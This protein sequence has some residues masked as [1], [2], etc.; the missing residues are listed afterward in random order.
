MIKK[1]FLVSFILVLQFL[2]AEVSITSSKYNPYVNEII[3]IKI[4]IPGNDTQAP[5]K[6][7]VE[8]NIYKE[9]DHWITEMSYFDT[10][11]NKNS[12][13]LVYTYVIL[14]LEP[15]ISEVYY[16]YD[17][18][19]SNI[20]SLNIEQVNLNKEQPSLQSKLSDNVIYVRE[21][22][23]VTNT[24]FSTKYV[25]D[26]NY[27]RPFSKMNTS[28]LDTPSRS[29]IMINGSKGQ[30][31]IVSAYSLSSNK[32]GKF[33]ISE[34]EISLGGELV[35]I[36]SHNVEVIKLPEN[37]NNTTI[38]GKSLNIE[39]TNLAEEYKNGD[40]IKF[41]I[42]ISGNANLSG[43]TSLKDYFKVPEYVT[44]SILSRS[45]NVF[46]REMQHN[47]KFSY[48]GTLNS[49]VGLTINQVE[50]PFFNT[51]DKTTKFITF[52]KL[53]IKGNIS[54]ILLYTG[55]IVLLVIV[56][57]VII[58][59]TNFLKKKPRDKK[60]DPI[61]KFKF[62]NREKDIFAI[63]VNGKSTKEIAE[64]LYISPETVKKHIQNILKKTNTN[65][66]LEL[67]AL[68]NSIK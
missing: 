30:Y 20:I 3:E 12:S 37:I 19:T 36:P 17:K 15:G 54:G 60:S 34:S 8:N 14:L 31:K 40:N 68:I 39:V 32:P 53:H 61:E 42:N 52:N 22:A 51:E 9:I 28:N 59:T 11:A 50:I 26:L 58:F 46:D 65:S 43:I 2:V 64:E 47:I 24:V 35:T 10:T 45:E 62:S 38:I 21:K 23:Y 56:F 7:I 66:R 4:N 41:F 57:V 44:E 25:D 48:I 27:T 67:L 1:V 33:I 18:W 49:I 55:I 63:L 6:L 13:Y 5:V 29:K 16:K